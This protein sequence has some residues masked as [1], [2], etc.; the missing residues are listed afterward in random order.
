MQPTCRKTVPYANNISPA[1][2][3]RNLPLHTL[4][5]LASTSAPRAWIWWVGKLP[6]AGIVKLQHQAQR[7][8]LQQIDVD[9]FFGVFET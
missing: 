2:L 6:R 3:A 7:I 8:Q 5:G 1:W 9:F 4:D